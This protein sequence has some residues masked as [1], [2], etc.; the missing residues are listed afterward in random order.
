MGHL[1][2]CTDR[3]L[4][5]TV[6]LNVLLFKISGWA[7]LLHLMGVRK[8]IDFSYK[9]KV[10]RI[11]YADV[12]KKIMQH[13]ICN[14]QSGSNSV[15]PRN[16]FF[17]LHSNSKNT[18]ICRCKYMPSISD[19]IYKRMDGFSHQIESHALVSSSLKIFIYII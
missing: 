18:V 5:I 11:C 3:G 12:R 2:C 14:T 16:F 1:H 13:S 17:K 4:S 19:I 7:K 8:L 10:T 6:L 15:T 9:L